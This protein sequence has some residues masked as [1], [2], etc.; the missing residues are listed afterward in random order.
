MTTNCN[1]N[2]QIMKVKTEVNRLKIAKKHLVQ[3][4]FC[5]ERLQQRS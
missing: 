3:P 1:T 5:K 2:Y 4:A